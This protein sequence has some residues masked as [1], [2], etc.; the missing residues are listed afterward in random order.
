MQPEEKIL[1][2]QQLFESACRVT[3]WGIRNQNPRAT[4]EQCL[5]ILR[6]R[7]ELQRK[8]EGSA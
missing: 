5:D 3:L 2:G 1:A 7:L 8:L 4:D 6:K